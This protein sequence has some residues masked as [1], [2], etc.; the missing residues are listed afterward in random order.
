MGFYHIAIKA[1]VPLLLSYIDYE[2]KIAGVGPPFY[3]TGDIEKDLKEIDNLK[4][5]QTIFTSLQLS[6]QTE[7]YIPLRLEPIGIYRTNR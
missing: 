6:N 3:P 5:N 4:G 1:N 2:K 7:E